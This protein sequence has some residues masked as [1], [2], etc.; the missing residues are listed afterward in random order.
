MKKMP[1]LL[2]RWLGIFIFFSLLMGCDDQQKN[3]VNQK[4]ETI[5]TAKTKTPTI[6]LY[7]SGVLQPLEMLSVLSPV[8]GRIVKLSFNYGQYVV[9]EQPLVILSS[10]TLTG[11]YRKTISDY[12]Q[13]KSTYENG[14]EDF[15]GTEAL[16]RAGVISREE[17]MTARSQYQTNRLNYYQSRF[18]MEKILHRAGI[19]PGEIEGLTL[20]DTNKVNRLLQRQFQHIVVKADGSGIALY[21]LKDDS[22]SGGGS[23][24]LLAVGGE[25]KQGQLM[26]LIGDLSGLSTM[27]QVSE[28]NIN[29]I[30][31]GMPAVITSS[32]FPRIVLH[33]NVSAVSSQ[34]QASQESSGLAMFQ[35]LVKIPNLTQKQ[36]ETI[37]VGMTA[38]VAIDVK[39]HSVVMLPIAAVSQK[40][41]RAVVTIIDKTGKRRTVPVLTGFTTPTEVSVIQ[42]VKDGD[43]VVVVVPAQ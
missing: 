35:V 26:L 17:Y 40:G 3:D 25:V 19:D 37:R 15:Q 8:S 12:L 13:K 5:V 24:K 2:V 16:Y 20:A 29:R 43:R 14:L 32:A 7:F 41:G 31:R 1:K 22:G 34:A 33:G 10:V 21:P 38:K 30:K 9:K 28:V 18:A 39:Q 42:G 11:N 6:H 4:K 27:I 23:S 36:R